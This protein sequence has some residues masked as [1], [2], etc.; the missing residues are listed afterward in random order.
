MA[1]LPINILE[2][3]QT[4]QEGGLAFLQNLCCFV[5]TANTRFKDFDKQLPANLGDTVT[6]DLPPR[7]TTSA[8]LKAVFQPS[9]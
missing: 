3:V 4:Y 6:F 2:Q 7:Y 5:K 9:T 8:G 1:D